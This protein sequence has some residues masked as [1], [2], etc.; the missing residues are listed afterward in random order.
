MG[1]KTHK[2]EYKEN[3]DEYNSAITLLDHQANLMWQENSAFML[4]VTILLGF[5]GTGL[6]DCNTAIDKQKYVLL[7]GSIL[8][9]VLSG[10]WF[11]T[12]H[13]NYPYYRLRIFQARKLKKTL[14]FL[15]LRMGIRSI[16]G[17]L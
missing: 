6:I 16:E 15:C 13:H 4:A 17:R 5:I 8:G 14:D 11:A 3:L 1:T 12:F 10:L 9:L 7:I 2:R